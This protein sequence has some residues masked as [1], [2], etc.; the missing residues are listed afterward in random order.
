MFSI[1]LFDRDSFSPTDFLTRLLLCFCLSQKVY[2][3]QTPSEHALV[4]LTQGDNMMGRASPIFCFLLKSFT[5]TEF[6]CRVTTTRR[7]RT[8]LQYDT[9]TRFY[10]ATFYDIVVQDVLAYLNIYALFYNF[11][12]YKIQNDK[13]YRLILTRLFFCRLL[14]GRNL[15]YRQRDRWLR[16]YFGSA[17]LYF[18]CR[19]YGAFFI[20]CLISGVYTPACAIPSLRDFILQETRFAYFSIKYNTL[21]RQ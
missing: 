14:L 16:L 5:S 20:Y 13:F 17:S 3:R 19:T 8:C 10:K 18:F 6:C 21:Q 1:I 9:S 7:L 2:R 15:F 11:I 12:F 4:P